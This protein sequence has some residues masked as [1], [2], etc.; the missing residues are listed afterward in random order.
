LGIYKVA[1]G[2]G[3]PGGSPITAT[4]PIT[5]ANGDAIECQYTYEI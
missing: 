4:S 2:T 3:Q 1:N 5:W